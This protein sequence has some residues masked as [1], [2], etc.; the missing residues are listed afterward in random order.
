[1]RVRLS[2]GGGNLLLNSITVG[3]PTGIQIQFDRGYDNSGSPGFY[4]DVP[5]GIAYSLNAFAVGGD[6]RSLDARMST[7]NQ[8]PQ[9]TP[10]VPA[11]V[12]NRAPPLGVFTLD[13][14]TLG[15]PDVLG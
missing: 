12:P 5:P 4:A 7:T 10:A 1:M 13:K 8:Y 3:L 11:S 6:A 14:S 2:G 9:V 15:G